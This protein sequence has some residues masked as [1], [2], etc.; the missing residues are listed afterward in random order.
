MASGSWR[1][2]VGGCTSALIVSDSSTC[3]YGPSEIQESASTDVN[4]RFFKVNP[5]GI[6]RNRCMAEKKAFAEYAVGRSEAQAG[7]PY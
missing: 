4:I 7:N 5:Y 1:Q 6:Y 2:K 3:T